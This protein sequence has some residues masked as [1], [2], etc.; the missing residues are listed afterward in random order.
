[1]PGA[2]AKRTRCVPERDAAGAR[3][4]LLTGA[5]ALGV[6][7]NAAQADALLGFGA[8]L[9]RWNQ[10]FNLVSRRDIER[11]LPRHL[12]D[13]LSA[14]PELAPSRVL[15]LGT[16]A[17]L[18][19]V[20]LAIVRP[21]LQFTLVDRNERKIRFIGQVARELELANVTPLCADVARM[22]G[23]ETFDTVVTRAVA[24]PAGVWALAEP[25]LA[26]A[27]RLVLLHRVHDGRAAP[28]PEAAA[29][30]S[31]AAPPGARILGRHLAA[32]PGLAERHEVLVLGR[33]DP[34][35]GAR[36]RGR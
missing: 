12:L 22:P 3:S 23:D 30:E 24:A 20:P 4:D 7:L 36:S 25:R 21:Q 19:G 35:H 29:A 33:A 5:A 18:P 2:A 31:G 11:L 26:P 27:G 28:A 8:L 14:A 15:D 17:G 13:S 6:D 32:I 9:A 16:G 1:M 10:A 34:A